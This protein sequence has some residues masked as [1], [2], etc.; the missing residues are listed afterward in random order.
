MRETRFLRFLHNTNRGG[1]LSAVFP[2]LALLGVCVLRA[3]T[4]IV[5]SGLPDNFDDR[6]VVR[7]LLQSLPR[8]RAIPPHEFV[9]GRSH[10]SLVVVCSCLIFQATSIFSTFKLYLVR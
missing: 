8:F 9:S 1:K 5:I 4:V 3:T 10:R 6:L 2:R 7:G